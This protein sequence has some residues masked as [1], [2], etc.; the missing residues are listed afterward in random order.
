MTNENGATRPPAVAGH[1]YPRSG[2][3][4]KAEVEGL[5]AEAHRSPGP[6]WPKAVIVPHAG[7]VYSGPVAARAYAALA[8]ARGRVSRV[9]LLGPAHFVHLRGLAAPRAGAFATPLGKVPV[10]RAA[11]DL[12]ADLPQVAIDDRPHVSEHSL[13]VQLPFLQTVLGSFGLVPLAVGEASEA[14]VAEVLAR[15]WDGPET[16][17][18]VSSDLSHYHGFA[19]AKRLDQSTAETIERFEGARL[20]AENACGYLPVAGLLLEAKRR[21]LAIERLDLRNSG[22]TAGPRHEV[23]GY[24]AWA[25]FEPEAC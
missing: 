11:L 14:E 15:L 9:V 20:T 3:S 18:V 8:P 2:P 17:I 24:G 23:V 21:R 25:L 13:E 22:E 16:L 12:I 19:E 10:E 6:R 5:L 7:Y 1:F 4:L